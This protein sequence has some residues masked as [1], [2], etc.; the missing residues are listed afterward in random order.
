MSL[1][2]PDFYVFLC[3]FFLFFTLLWYDNFSIHD[4][5]VCLRNN[6][7]H[8]SIEETEHF[9]NTEPNNVKCKGW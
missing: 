1:T 5:A 4:F 7:C 2:V 9:V 8:P 6:V 3:T